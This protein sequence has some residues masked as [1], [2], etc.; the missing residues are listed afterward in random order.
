MTFIVP[1][2]IQALRGRNREV[3]SQIVTEVHRAVA[4]APPLPEEPLL[5][6]LGDMFSTL[7]EKYEGMQ[8]ALEQIIREAEAAL[9][10]VQ[11][12][13]RAFAAASAQID[14]YSGDE[15]MEP[16]ADDVYGKRAKVMMPKAE[17]PAN[18]D[19][20]LEA[21]RQ[22]IDRDFGQGT[23]DEAYASLPEVGMTGGA[24]PGETTTVAL[25]EA[26]PVASLPEM[27]I[28][29]GKPSAGRKRANRATDGDHNDQSGEATPG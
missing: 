29:G 5:D 26:V 20:H 28:M 6:Y 1:K 16:P 21:T 17:P 24:S 4:A 27:P 13:R 22:M 14:P 7:M 23:F 8:E 2:I 11:T 19:P 10:D 18:I 9:V 12:A 3:R 25:P 15:L